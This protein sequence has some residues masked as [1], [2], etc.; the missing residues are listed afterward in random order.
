M[1]LSRRAARL[2]VPCLA[3]L[4][5]TIL[6][7]DALQSRFVNED[8]VFLEKEHGHEPVASVT[9]F[10]AFANSYPW[11]SRQAY[12]A[13]LGLTA[14]GNALVFHLVNLALLGV[15]LG[16][17]ADLLRALLPPAGV[18]VG[19]LYFALLP[20]QRVNLMSVSCGQDLLALVGSLAALALYRKGRI[21]LAVVAFAIALMSKE[22]ALA[23][24]IAL[25]AW[26]M[27]IERRKLNSSVVR[28]AP[29]AVLALVWAAAVLG[30]SL[31]RGT[32]TLAMKPAYW[33]A[34]Y[35]H[36]VQSLLGLENPS[37]M[38]RALSR[39]APPALPLALLGA[40]ALLDPIPPTPAPVESARP[41]PR[42]VAV[43]GCLWVLALGAVMG[44]AV[45][46]WSAFYYTQAAVGAALLLGLALARADRWT[47][48][49]LTV[50]LL[51]WHTG[52]SHVRAFGVA[53]RP[54]N[55]TSH[56]TSFY[57]ER[58]STLAETVAR[59]L[60]TL[61]PRPD[62]GTRFFFAT[63][64]PWAGFQ[65][66]NDALVR[67]LYNDPSLGSF[68]YSQF[69]ESTAADKPCHFLY[70][71]GSALKPLYPRARDPYFQVGSDLL[72]LGRLEGAAY[73]F[74]RGLAAGGERMDHLY[75]LGWTS[76]WSGNRTSA[77]RW[78]RAFG[79]RDD[80]LLWIAH[81]RSA[82]NALNDR[83]TL[84]AR[85]HLA[86]AI[87]YGIGRPEAHAVLGEL[88]MV[89]RP[90]YALLELKV[91]TWL[92]PEDWLARRDF[93]VGL[94]RAR[95]DVEARRELEALQAI[96]PEWRG[97]SLLV[98]ADRTLGRRSGRAVETATFE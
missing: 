76:I 28:A 86:T 22:S 47:R 72:L 73:A 29:F 92:K 68:F 67:V 5:L 94:T 89:D 25:L 74:R 62:P 33:V 80:S 44:P 53:D 9:G 66:G 51:W 59:Q 65:N 71:D 7:A 84:E 3:A 79:A 96:Y 90:K 46:Q 87:Q 77:E 82:H 2:I 27:L 98:D 91:A 40:A 88:L 37:G 56:V 54:W 64:P 12:F 41:T 45:H 19:L 1:T 26:D 30:V 23:L 24:P 81:L 39:H 31:F 17:L 75:W 15:A 58:A 8:Y 42:V 78:W 35:A 6:F 34:G 70:W 21:A 93:V 36:L 60:K 97:D 16:L 13:L 50:V 63:L 52:A 55:W 69:S 57:L 11:L 4:G 49:G 14:D 20:L 85:R 18:M 32:G 10:G 95:L 61:V 38:M 43:L 83:D 48:L